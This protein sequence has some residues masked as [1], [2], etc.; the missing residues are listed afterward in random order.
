MIRYFHIVN[1]PVYLRI[2]REAC[3][4]RGEFIYWLVE[5]VETF[6]AIAPVHRTAK[7]T[8]NF[9]VDDTQVAASGFIPLER[10]SIARYR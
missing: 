9:E 6:W 2:D 10:R 1:T 8:G 3:S 4:F 5:Q 7:P